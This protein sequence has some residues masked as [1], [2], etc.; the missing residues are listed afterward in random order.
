[1]VKVRAKRTLFSAKVDDD[2]KYFIYDSRKKPTIRELLNYTFIMTGSFDIDIVAYEI[3]EIVL[4]MPFE[5]FYEK[6]SVELTNK[7]L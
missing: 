7:Q 3:F 5:T 2:I 1:M 4:S 6:A